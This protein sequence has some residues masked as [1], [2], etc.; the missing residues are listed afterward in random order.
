MVV[1]GRKQGESRYLQKHVIIDLH[2]VL[3]VVEPQDCLY[4][5]VGLAGERPISVLQEE[6]KGG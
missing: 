3:G 1:L 6:S 5:S 2:E 4:E